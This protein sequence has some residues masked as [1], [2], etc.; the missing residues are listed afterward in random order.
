M[1]AVDSKFPNLDTSDITLLGIVTTFVLF[2]ACVPLAVAFNGYVLSVLWDWFIVSTF[3]VPHI[4]IPVGIGIMSI[5]AFLT[6]GISKNAFEERF[7]KVESLS[8][9]QLTFV[10]AS[11]GPGGAALLFSW[12]VTKFM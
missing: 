3:A 7:T 10:V 5:V 12:I 11:F 8:G 2:V 4:S 6:Q 9:L 1:K